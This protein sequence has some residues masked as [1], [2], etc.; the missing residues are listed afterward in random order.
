MALSSDMAA[1]SS[2]ACPASSIMGKATGAAFLR[3]SADSRAAEIALAALRS[4]VRN[5]GNAL[6]DPPSNGSLPCALGKCPPGV[7]EASAFSTRKSLARRTHLV[8]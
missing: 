6:E 2:W 3:A 1:V 8:G 5:A 4:R 7:S